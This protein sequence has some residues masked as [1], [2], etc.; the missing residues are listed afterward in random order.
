MV[1]ELLAVFHLLDNK[2]VINIHKP[3]PRW[4]GQSADGLGFN[5]LHEQVGYSWTNGGEP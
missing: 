3:K 1:Y 4:I 5:V 2:G